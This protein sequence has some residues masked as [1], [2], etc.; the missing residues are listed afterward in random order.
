MLGIG[1]GSLLPAAFGVRGWGEWSGAAAVGR[2][3]GFVARTRGG[4]YS[5]PLVGQATG[6]PYHHHHDHRLNSLIS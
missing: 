6:S 3:I 1:G 4:R 5:W 2:I